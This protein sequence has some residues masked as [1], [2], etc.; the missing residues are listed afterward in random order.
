LVYG[1]L[2]LLDAL[3]TRVTGDDLK[4]RIKVFDDLDARVASDIE[5]VKDKLNT[6]GYSDLI[7]SG[8]IFDSFQIFIPVSNNKPDYVDLTGRN[9]FYWTIITFGEL[10]KDI[11]RYS[12]ANN[13]PLR[14]CI[15][16]GNAELTS[17]NRV[18][19]PAATEAAA[20]Y[21][22]TEWMGIIA[23]SHPAL[24]LENK[25]RLNPNPD[26]YEPFVK[27][28]VPVKSEIINNSTRQ[29]QEF[30]VLDWP[31]HYEYRYT[32]A[33][34]KLICFDKSFDR[35]VFGNIIPNNTINTI[36]SVGLGNEVADI[37]T[38][39]SNTYDFFKARVP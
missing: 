25:H 1:V 31:I 27:Y 19:G 15:S 35:T 29:K 38:K 34:E 23:T 22:I 14:G 11:F 12:L 17:T 6:Y 24:V 7:Y 16:S 30:W 21:E 26:M 20:H 32:S 2:V 4:R 33:D 39:Y 3:G 37:A 5:T 9:E 8:T 36:L 18:L 28:N 13:I 10:L